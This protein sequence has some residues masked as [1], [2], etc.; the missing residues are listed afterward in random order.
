MTVLFVVDPRFVTL[1]HL[2]K[3]WHRIAAAYLHLML[4]YFPNLSSVLVILLGSYCL[5]METS[6]PSIS[7]CTERA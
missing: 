4:V 6:R 7:G 1:R 2:I 5:H 3:A